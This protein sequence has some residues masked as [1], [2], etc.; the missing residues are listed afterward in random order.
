MDNACLPP[1][2]SLNAGL[3]H[4]SFHSL[5][6]QVLFIVIAI[7]FLL[8]TYALDLLESRRCTFS[9][10]MK[11]KQLF[12]AGN[13][14][15]AVRKVCP[16][17]ISDITNS[18]EKRIYETDKDFLGCLDE[19]A[20]RRSWDVDFYEIDS[21]TTTRIYH[22]GCHPDFL[23]FERSSD[24]VRPVRRAYILIPLLFN[25]MI[26]VT[27]RVNRCA[28]PR[29]DF[30]TGV[31]G[32]IR[33]V[34]VVSTVR[35]CFWYALYIEWNAPGSKMTVVHKNDVLTTPGKLYPDIE[36]FVAPAIPERKETLWSKVKRKL[37]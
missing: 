25:H 36:P 35:L 22:A 2:L 31:G 23:G 26:D 21:G 18:L 10:E 13:R 16:Q 9:S 4:F 19:L 17:N 29:G 5:N 3:F 37:L 24:S 33:P 6:M 20:K 8:Y 7:V 34:D 28:G 12:V 27:E 15:T 1:L 14:V 32:F 30:Y 11:R